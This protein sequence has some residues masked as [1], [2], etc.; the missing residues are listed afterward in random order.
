[1]MSEQVFI[2]YRREGGIDYAMLLKEKLK[3]KGYTVFLD[4]TSMHA[5]RFDYHIADA[6][7][8][9]TDFLLIV[10][11]DALKRCA[12]EGDWVRRE[13]KY[14]LE[15]Q[16]NII[17]I[18]IPGGVFPDRLPAD[19]NNVRFMNGIEYSKTYLDNMVD[20]LTKNYM[21][22]IP[23]S[24]TYN[25][26]YNYSY[27]KSVDKSKLIKIGAISLGSLAAIGIIAGILF[28]SGLGAKLFCKHTYGTS[29][30]P[31]TCTAQGYTTYL[32][33]ECGETEDKDYVAA[34]GHKWTDVVYDSVPTCTAAGYG[35]KNC[36]VCDAYESSSLAAKGHSYSE[37]VIDK[38]GTKTENG[39]RHKICAEC[40]DYVEEIIYATGSEGL[41]ITK[42]GSSYVVSGIGT[43]TDE[44]IIIPPSVEGLPVTKI[45]D[46]A[47]K[48]CKMIV[49]VSIPDCVDTIGKNA[50]KDCVSLVEIS[51]PSEMTEINDYAFAGCKSLESIVIPNGITHIRNHCFSGCSS[52]LSIT[53]P[54]SV[55][56]FE[57][58]CFNSSGIAQVYY[59]GTKVLWHEIGTSG[60]CYQS[61]GNFTIYCSDGEFKIWSMEG[62]FG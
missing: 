55:V 43:C 27:K 18:M 15:Y 32:C 10:S 46:G 61:C 1:M 56:K 22:S 62:I 53:I 28:F 36:S 2:S 47:F 12:N 45:A 59:E 29:L 31:P 7:K 11:P 30:T 42:S 54:K 16:K 24:Y 44:D 5:G 14:A 48:G 35:T 23:A 60:G 50:F 20:N 3:N 19:I 58:Y 34:L 38:S 57:A 8:E 21:R 40:D 13:I 26:N 33:S 37:W 41:K 6:I 17:P 4:M 39:L 49:S 51:L 52:L 9:C 25:Y